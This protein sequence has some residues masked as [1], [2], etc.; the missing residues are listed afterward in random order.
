MKTISDKFRFMFFL[1]PISSESKKGKTFLTNS[2]QLKG[3]G[4]IIYHQWV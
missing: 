2:R 3:L 4:L 1:N